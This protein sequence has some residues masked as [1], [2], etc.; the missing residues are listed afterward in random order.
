MS[1]FGKQTADTRRCVFC[2]KG[3]AVHLKQ[4]PLLP[5]GGS[6]GAIVAT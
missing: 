3:M 1:A 4:V 6:A 5:R 2:G